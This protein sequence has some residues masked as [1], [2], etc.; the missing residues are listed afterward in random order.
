MSGQHSVGRSEKS[1]ESGMDELARQILDKNPFLSN[2]VSDPSGMEADVAAIHERPFQTLL[3]CADEVRREQGHQGQIVWGEAG[4]GKSHLLAR[5][6]RWA[7]Q[8]DRAVVVFLH[9]LQPS[10]EMLPRYVVKCVAHRLAGQT[11]A[12]EQG[13]ALYDLVTGAV[14]HAL[15]ASGLA[16]A[17]LPAARAYSEYM[18]FIEERIARHPGAGLDAR[19]AYDVLFRY[20]LSK[21]WWRRGGR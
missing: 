21:Y 3:H 15:E 16:G 19:D 14:R 6:C 2:A 17:S 1:E 12:N 20:F 9:N 11:G 7:E 8:S 18:R 13:S 4:V 5:F 10:A